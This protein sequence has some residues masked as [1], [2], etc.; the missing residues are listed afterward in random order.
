MGPAT[1][2]GPQGNHIDTLPGQAKPQPLEQH[3]QGSASCMSVC[4]CVFVCV[5]NCRK[6]R[7]GARKGA[8][9]PNPVAGAPPPQAPVGGRELLH[10][11]RCRRTTA[12]SPPEVGCPIMHRRGSTGARAEPAHVLQTQRRLTALSSPPAAAQ[13]RLRSLWWLAAGLQPGAGHWRWPF[14]R[15]APNCAR[16]P[17]VASAC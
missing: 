16:P 6:A 9:P 11:P 12:T 14:P 15:T 2:R 10:Q 13:G 3:N 5:T 7:L 1:M 4:V 17:P 8:A